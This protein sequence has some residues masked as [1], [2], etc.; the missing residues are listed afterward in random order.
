MGDAGKPRVLI[1][2]DESPYRQAVADILQR[3]RLEVRYAG[4]AL[5]GMEVLRS[6]SPDVLLLDV[7]MPNVSGLT[8]LKRLRADPRWKDLPVVMVS[9]LARKDDMEAGKAAGANEYLTKPFTTADL[10]RVLRRFIQVLGTAELEAG[11]D[12]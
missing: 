12:S 7:M 5:E 9:A 4:D 1:V 3:S 10:R 8:L 2:D 6:W 11:G